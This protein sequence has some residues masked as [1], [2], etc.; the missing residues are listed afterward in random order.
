MPEPSFRASPPRCTT[1]RLSRYEPSSLEPSE[2]FDP[3]ARAAATAWGAQT[4]SSL[5]NAGS[6]SA[7]DVTAVRDGSRRKTER[8]IVETICL[9]RFYVLFLPRT[10]E[11]TRPHRRLHRQPDRRLGGSTV[12][13][14]SFSSPLARA[15]L[16]IRDRDSKFS[17][18]SMRSSRSEGIR[19][20]RT[21]V[22]APNA[23]ALVSHCTS[24]C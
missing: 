9:R 10:R 12:R 14:L 5:Q 3:I 20:I 8:L 19:V 15:R 6:A 1:E 23:K 21:P 2:R 22:Q 17:P 7:A 11:Q 18:A 24:W 13:N 16:L 4:R